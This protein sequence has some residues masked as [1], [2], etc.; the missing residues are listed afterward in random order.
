[1]AGILSALT[2][3]S[4]PTPDISTQLTLAQQNAQKNRN[5]STGLLGQLQ[6]LTGQFTTGANAITTGAGD[7]AKAAA[8]GLQGN[9][10][11]NTKEA[12][13]SLRKSL[14][15]NTFSALPGTLQATREA[16]AA[17]GGV[18]SGA[19]NKS[20]EQIG[21]GTA[22]T[23]AQGEAGIQAQGAQAKTAAATQAY[24][25]VQNVMNNLTQDQL[26]TLQ[27]AFQSGRTDLIQNAATQMGLNDQET[28][29]LIQLYNF[30]QSGQMASASADAA[31]NQQ[32][33]SGI[34]GA[35]ATYAGSKKA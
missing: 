31:A 7:A 6:P 14:Y 16:A 33:L 34:I 5:I 2:G 8:A 23:I 4:I 3:S 1:M 25:T 18:N 17:G 29:A 20:V 10:A 9:V 19:Y 21:Q 11:Q 24:Q 28:Q 27:T 15:S 13:D 35:G 30:Q 26:G 22:Q 32:L 12:Q